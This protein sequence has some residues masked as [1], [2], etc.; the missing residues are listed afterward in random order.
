[1]K[2]P[3]EKEL[4]ISDYDHTMELSEVISFT[5]MLAAAFYIFVHLCLLV[6]IRRLNRFEGTWQPFVSVIVAARNE[7][8]T[9]GALLQC[10]L[11]QTYHTYEVIIVNDRSTDSTAEIIDNIQKNNSIIKRIDI[12]TVTD[13]MPSKKNALRAGIE[14]SKGEL[15]CFT[16]ADC[17]PPPAWIEQL[18]RGFEPDVGLVSG[19]SPYQIPDANKSHRFSNYLS[20]CFFRFIAYEELRAAIWSAGAIGLNV[21][22][23]CTGR[24]LAYRRKTYDE[25]GGYEKIKM[26]VSGDDDL[27]LQLVRKHTK[28][29]IRYATAKEC[30]VPTASP[31][32]LQAFIEQRKRH[33]SAAKYFSVSMKLFFFLYHTSNL[34]L[35]LSPFL[36]VFNFL[37]LTTLALYIFS[38]LIVDTILIIPSLRIFDNPQF[39]VSFLFM[40]VLYVVYNTIIGPLG[41][42]RKF[43]WK[44]S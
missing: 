2:F 4:I 5:L 15:L 29:R 40:E 32:T 41:L 38:K 3:V 1:M 39:R 20:T 22:W 36:F 42:L 16:D 34:L 6:G 10:L 28:W 7:Q 24:N 12:T 9:I 18:V 27:F 35:L 26:S 43:K 17:F 30:F 19:Y 25:L 44:P 37:A 23:L 33:F 13:D 21:G 11:H 8:R 31:S 14:M